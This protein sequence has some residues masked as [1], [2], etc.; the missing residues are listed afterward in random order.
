MSFFFTRTG[1][2]TWGLQLAMRTPATDETPSLSRHCNILAE[3]EVSFA[4]HV[5]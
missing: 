2:F 5:A 3:R 4:D 1:D